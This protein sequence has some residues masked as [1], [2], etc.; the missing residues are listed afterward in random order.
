MRGMHRAGPPHRLGGMHGQFRTTFQRLLHP[1]ADTR[2]VLQTYAAIT[3]VAGISITATGIRGIPGMLQVHASLIWIGGMVGLAAGCAAAGLSLNDDPVGR[4]RSTVWFAIGHLLLGLMVLMQW[5]LYWKQQGLPFLVAIGP[6]AAAAVLLLFAI[7]S[8]PREAG[9]SASTAVGR[10]R[11][12]YDD[13]IREVARREERARL[14]RDLHDAVKQQL[15][16]IQTAAATAQARL[17]GDPVGAR[18]AVGHVR[19]AAREATTEMEALLDELQGAPLENTG[20]VETL[21]KQCEALALRTGSEVIFH[22]GTLPPAG[23]LPPGAHEAIYRVAQEALANVARHARAKRV[24][25]TLSATS[26][27]LGLRVADDGSGFETSEQRRGM[28]ITNMETRAAEVGG[29][30]RVSRQSPGTDVLLT[31]PLMNSAVRAAWRGVAMVA[32]FALSQ[33]LF[34]GIRGESRDQRTFLVVLGLM[35]AWALWGLAAAY[36]RIG[37]RGRHA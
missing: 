26:T 8:W 27:E 14:A 34:Y 24:E 5:P 32:L 20:L 22:P 18:E 37:I 33:A 31:V 29:R 1:D 10:V 2:F 6:F 4:R 13:H 35:G 11:S 16:V 21:K 15:F 23:S 12:R 17:D 36:L 9:D 7:P 30:V 3:I 25:V 28:G 19:S